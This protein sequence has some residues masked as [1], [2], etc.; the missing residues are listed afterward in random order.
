MREILAS[1]NI[2]MQDF[3]INSFGHEE[4][5]IKAVLVVTSITQEEMNDILNELNS[6][7]EVEY[8]FC[9]LM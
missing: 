7:S 8:A 9:S 1:V 5:I 4:V 2:Q 6:I 3:S